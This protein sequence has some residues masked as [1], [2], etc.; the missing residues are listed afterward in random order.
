MKARVLVAC[1]PPSAGRGTDPYVIS[2]SMGGRRGANARAFG[3]GTRGA[4]VVTLSP[5][6]RE[7]GPAAA[8]AAFGGHPRD[9]FRI[10]R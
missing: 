4:W 7:A 8:R 5:Q 9:V 3:P 6:L 10:R 2:S 1:L